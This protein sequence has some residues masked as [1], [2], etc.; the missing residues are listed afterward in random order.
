MSEAAFLFVCFLSHLPSFLPHLGPQGLGD[1]ILTKETQAFSGSFLVSH[2]LSDIG[3][4]PS[5]SHPPSQWKEDI[6][7]G[8]A[9]P[10]CNYEENVKDI[11]VFGMI[12]Q[13]NQFQNPELWISPYGEEHP[14]PH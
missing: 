14:L 12:Y 3:T 1:K 6:T 7:V 4:T 2:L 5:C 11:S 8:V 10:F 9:Q 13:A